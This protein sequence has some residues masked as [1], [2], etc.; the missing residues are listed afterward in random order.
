MLS[1]SLTASTLL[2]AGIG[3]PQLRSERWE[4][5]KSSTLK[6]DLSA[7]SLEGLLDADRQEES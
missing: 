2:N 4:A 6:R 5:S 3:K 7:L 1:E